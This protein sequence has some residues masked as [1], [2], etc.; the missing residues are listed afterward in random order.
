MLLM[1]KKLFA[2][3]CLILVA[4]GVDLNAPAVSPA[5]TGRT[6][7]E[8]TRS[9]RARRKRPGASPQVREVDAAGLAKLLQPESAPQIKPLLVNFWATWCVPCRE[10]FPDLVKINDEFAP[11]G[12]NFITVS[13]DD[14]TEINKTVPQFLREMRATKMPAYLLNTPEPE[15]A[16]NAVDPNWNGGLPATFLFGAHGKLISSQ[17]GRVKPNELKQ[18]IEFALKPENRGL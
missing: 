15:T 2:V 13:L 7:R 11:R 1:L 14:P 17:V 18:A 10:E 12:L 9:Q 5:A 8:Q 3:T 16:I 6:T 4:A